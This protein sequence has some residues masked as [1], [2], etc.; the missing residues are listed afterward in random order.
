MTGALLYQ[1]STAAQLVSVLMIALFYATLARSLRRAEVV[2]WA[3][4]WWCN[5][6]A[7]ALAFTYWFVTPPPV[8]AIVLRSLYVAGKIAYVLLLIEGAWALREPGGTWLSR[9]TLGVLIG[10]SVLVAA[11]FLSSINLVGIAVQ[12]TMGALFLWCGAVLFRERAKLTAWLGIAFLARGSFALIEAIA[13]GANTFPSGT[14]SPELTTRIAL[15][16]GAHSSIDLAAEWL[17]ALGGSV[18]IAR[19]AQHELQSAN[20]GLLCVQD[21]LRRLVDVDPLTELANRRALPEAF[22]DVFLTGAILVF[23]DIDDFKQVNDTYGHSAG[24]VC[25]QRFAGALRT[26]FRPSDVIVRYA[27]DEFLVVCKGMDMATANARVDKL[28][29]RLTDGGRH[30]IPLDFSAGVAELRPKQDS[31]EALRE[32]D[33]AMY[34][35]KTARV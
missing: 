33:A 8:G 22:R 2:W 29:Q 13:Y 12:G 11:V 31:D 20:D 7:L 3:R 9:R 4:G 14:F 10:T 32:A 34:A 24:D 35:A 19:R 28:R 16:L 5:F 26:T 18:A 23:C 21:E 25:L 17:L 15:F 27:G 6:A 30:E 1:W